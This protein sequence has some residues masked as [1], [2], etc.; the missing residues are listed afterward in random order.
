MLMVLETASNKDLKSALRLLSLRGANTITLI[1]VFI[2]SRLLS[3]RWV[4]LSIYSLRVR[5]CY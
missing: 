4:N 3:L 2:A 5:G 1:L